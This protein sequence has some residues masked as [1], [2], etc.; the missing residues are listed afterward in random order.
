MIKKL[1]KDLVLS[2]GKTIKAGQ[3][4]TD[5]KTGENILVVTTAKMIELEILGYFKA[6]KR[7][8]NN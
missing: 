8:I 6:K 4:I 5:T 7:N 1:V 3:Q 2:S